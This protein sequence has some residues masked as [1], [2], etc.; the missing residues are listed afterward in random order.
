[1]RAA[2]DPERGRTS[3]GHGARG[4]PAPR[5]LWQ[6]SLVDSLDLAEQASKR[7][8]TRQT[9]TPCMLTHRP[10]L[11]GD[12][13]IS[14]ER[15]VSYLRTDSRVAAHPAG[16]LT[17]LAACGGLKRRDRNRRLASLQH[18]HVCPTWFLVNRKESP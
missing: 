1:M 6:Q 3:L 12:Y 2:D 8:R 14:L 11:G 17:D 9:P 15:S 16:P 4:V 5:K 7:L 18:G 13:G 10:A